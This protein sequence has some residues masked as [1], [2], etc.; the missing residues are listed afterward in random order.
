MPCERT[1][2]VGFN[3]DGASKFRVKG[4]IILEFDYG[5]VKFPPPKKK[6]KTKN[7]NIEVIC[8]Q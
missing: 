6:Q 2:L 1:G 8:T 7:S 3:D 4:R 5:L